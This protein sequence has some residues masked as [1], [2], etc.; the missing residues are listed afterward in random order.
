M[1]MPLDDEE[2][3]TGM[4]MLV[5]NLTMST[6]EIY[7][8]ES[9]LDATM[10]PSTSIHVVSGHDGV[11]GAAS[12]NEVVL[13]MVVEEDEMYLHNGASFLDGHGNGDDADE[14]A[15]DDEKTESDDEEGD[16]LSACISSD[17][18]ADKSDNE[19]QVLY[20][21]I[22]ESFDVAAYFS[23]GSVTLTYLYR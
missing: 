23:W 2:V 18:F 1:L 17:V 7:I 14:D 15:N 21:P 5:L 9:S 16:I 4:W 3:V 10:T 13:N 11:N 20:F 8:E 6:M 22:L 19:V 12:A